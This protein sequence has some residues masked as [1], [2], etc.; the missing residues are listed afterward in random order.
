MY[1]DCSF[2]TV[3]KSKKKNLNLKNKQKKIL[4]IFVMIDKVS[5]DQS[6]NDIFLKL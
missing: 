5:V 3:K 4:T 2:H 6:V 1:T